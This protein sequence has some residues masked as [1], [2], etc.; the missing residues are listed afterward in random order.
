MPIIP[1][2]TGHSLLKKLATDQKRFTPISFYNFDFL[3]LS[4]QKMELEP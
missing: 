1:N 2:L 3:I 4:F